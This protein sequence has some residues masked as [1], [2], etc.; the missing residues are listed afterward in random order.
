MY[1][2]IVETAK[3]NQD[4]GYI[5]CTLKMGE[6]S[7]IRGLCLMKLSSETLQ[8]LSYIWNKKTQIDFCHFSFVTVPGLCHC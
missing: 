4:Q 6:S 1:Y 7:E 8:N 5:F 2:N 3:N